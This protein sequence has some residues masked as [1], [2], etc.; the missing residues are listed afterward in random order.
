MMRN[1]MKI[2]KFRQGFHIM[3]PF[4]WIDIKNKL[5]GRSPQA[6]YTDRA[7]AARQRS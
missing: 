7:T 6:N 1:F 2:Y 4:C 5:R 3:W